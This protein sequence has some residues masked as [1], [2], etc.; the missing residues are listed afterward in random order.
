VS[1]PEELRQDDINATDKPT[2]VIKEKNKIAL[3]IILF[4]MTF[5]TTTLAGVV[6]LNQP[7]EVEN[8]PHGL[9]YSCCLLLVLATHEFGHYFASR[10]HGVRATLPYFIPF[11]ATETWL[12]F[13]TLGAVIRTRSIVQNRKAMFDIG[14]AGPIAGFIVILIILI[15]GFLTLP[16]VE[17][18][19]AFIRSMPFHEKFAYPLPPDYNG[20]LTFGKPLLYSLL[21]MLFTDPSRQFIPPM[22]EVYHFP[23]LCVGWF[24]LFVTALNLIPV[25]QLDGGHI[26]YTM[27][28]G[29]HKIISRICFGGL[30]SYGLLGLLPLLGLHSPYGYSGWVVWSMLL[31][32]VIRLDHPTIE[33]ATPL[34]SKRMF[35]GWFNFAVLIVSFS[36]TPISLTV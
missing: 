13:G 28:G 14:A 26:A 21:E 12:N 2:A 22:S 31:Y 8:I 6:W 17:H 9:P 33:D 18:G 1:F 10:Y 3:H 4:L 24:G 27:F 30:L 7:L 15:T 19:V 25:G 34:D 23:L 5:V 20:G 36:P 32:F 29:S 11:P 16:S 35:L